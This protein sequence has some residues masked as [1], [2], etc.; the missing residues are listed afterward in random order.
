MHDDERENQDRTPGVSRIPLFGNLFKRKATQ[1]TTNEIL[2]FITPRIT[3]PDYAKSAA[4]SATTIVQPVPLG[5]PPSNSTP[6]ADNPA[7]S[8]PTPGMTK[9]EPVPTGTP[10]QGGN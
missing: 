5:N 7:G 10:K 6:P 8:T 2:F 1:R 9:P 4:P 3:R